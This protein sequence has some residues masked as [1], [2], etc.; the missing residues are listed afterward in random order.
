MERKINK[1][2]IFPNNNDKSINVLKK[3]RKEL[4]EKN[5]K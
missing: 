5:L 1:V 4:I 3:L 2:K